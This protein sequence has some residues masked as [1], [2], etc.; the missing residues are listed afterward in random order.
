MKRL[1]C[2]VWPLAVAALL[3]LG[4]SARAD[5]SFREVADQVNKKMVKLHG[6][7]GIRGLASYG[8]GILVS[9]DGYVLTINSPLLDTADLRVHMSDGYRYHAKVVAV[10]GELDVALVKID[11]G[12]EKVDALPYFDVFEAAKRPVADPGTGVLAFS[13]Q[14][15]IAS[16]DEPMSVQR[17]VI[18]SYCKL[19][20]RIGI[21][22]AP[23][24]GEVYV[25]DAITNNPG[26]AGG[27]LT[28]RKGNLLGLVGKELRNEQTNTWI[29]YAMPIGASVVVKQG[30]EER[31][32]SILDLVE[33]KEQYKPIDP[34]RKRA[35]GG[36]GHHGIIF[37]PDLLP[38]TP[39]YVDDVEPN[40]P[41]AKAGLK[42]DDLIVYVDGLPVNSIQMF[43]DIVDKYRPGTEVKLE[44]KRVDRLQTITLKLD[45]MPKGA[46]PEKPPEKPP[47]K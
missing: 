11:F 20:G 19:H 27:A 39:P 9:P 4:A 34:D 37:V 3:G 2:G 23:Y 16:R 6:A 21:F 44:V 46:A 36:G 29:N 40:S 30:K 43:R 28:D 38:R 42:P 33:K 24:T 17:G 32:V 10:E 8:S 31:K 45:A 5:V 47:E 13:N 26:G 25:L 1:R 12:R 14:F 41:A 18:A 7:G 22:E 35:E 15:R